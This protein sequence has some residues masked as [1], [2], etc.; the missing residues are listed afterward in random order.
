[1]DIKMVI[2]FSIFKK[3]SSCLSIEVI[4]CNKYRF[5]VL[6]AKEIYEEIVL[7]LT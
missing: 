7:M 3:K 4:F 2:Y 6:I 5:T 1:M